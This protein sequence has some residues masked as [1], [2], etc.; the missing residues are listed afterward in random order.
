MRTPSPRRAIGLGEWGIGRGQGELSC[1]GLGSCIALILDDRQALVGGLAHIVLPS[2]S[3]SRERSNPVR[4]A[5]TAVPFLIGEMVRAGAVRGQLTARL[6]GGASLFAALSTPG[7]VQIGQRNLLACRAAL[8]A[9]GV[10][11]VGEA[12]GG[13]IGRSVWFAIDTGVVM[14]RSVGHVP[15]QL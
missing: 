3:L 5:D 10:A 2:P 7:T 15:E 4:F 8:A 1:L 13:E 6:V 9:A 11:L 14:V 12:V